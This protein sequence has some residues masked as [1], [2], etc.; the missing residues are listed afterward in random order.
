MKTIVS[1]TSWPPR[2]DYVVDALNVFFQQT[3]PPDLIELTL[4]R[5]EF[6][7]GID[8]LPDALLHLIASRDITVFW[9]EGNAGVFRKLIPC[10]QRHQGEDAVILTVDDDWVYERDYVEKML[11]GIDGYDV[12]SPFTN[13]TGAFT[14]YRTSVLTPELW[15][16]LTPEVISLAVDDTWYRAFLEWRGAR[17]HFDPRADF[18]GY[19]LPT[20]LA[21]VSPNSLKVDGGYTERRCTRAAVLSKE[22]FNG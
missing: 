18:R 14:A 2:I 11:K 10:A 3:V 5:E 15:E 8:D 17:C 16:R 6:P 7:N 4:S 21:D 12:Y 22:A 1:M 20:G 9:E 19:A 13:V